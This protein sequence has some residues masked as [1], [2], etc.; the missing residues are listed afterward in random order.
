MMWDSDQGERHSRARGRQGVSARPWLRRLRIQVTASLLFVALAAGSAAV[1]SPAVIAAQATAAT[2]W[3]M[4]QGNPS[5]SGQSPY[6]GLS[7]FPLELWRIHLAPL[8][9]PGE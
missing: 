1:R 9:S 3:S 5:H 7:T 6:Q 2:T 4:Y 8:S